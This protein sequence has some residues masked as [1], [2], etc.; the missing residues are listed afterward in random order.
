MTPAHNEDRSRTMLET[1]D[2][3]HCA[4]FAA[5]VAA[6]GLVPPIPIGFIPVP[7]TAQTLGVML[8]G[9]VLG[10]RRGLIALLLV[11]LLAAVGLPI[12]SGGRGGLAVLLGPTGGFALAWPLGAFATGWLA[13]R[14]ERPGLLSLFACCV[15]GGIGVV[16]L[17]GISW[18][19]VVSGLPWH[20]AALGSLAFVPGDLI[21]AGVAAFAAV[22]LRRAYPL[23]SMR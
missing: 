4:L 14:R 6:L 23:A 10:A 7:I 8:A 20:Q 22:T 16:Y 19:A 21:K 12:L 2:I 5:I 15:A 1:R 3:V 13:E 11:V 9:A 18:L 17:G